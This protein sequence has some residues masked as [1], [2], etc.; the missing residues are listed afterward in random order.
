MKCPLLCIMTGGRAKG[1]KS[2][3]EDCLLT[4][5]A[6]WNEEKGICAIPVIAKELSRLQVKIKPREAII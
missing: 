6:W 3:V 2:V 1:Y 5:C 4:E